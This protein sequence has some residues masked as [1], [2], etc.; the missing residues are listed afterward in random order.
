MNVCRM[1]W[2]NVWRNRRR[3]IVTIAAMTL[4]LWVMV[5]YSGMLVGY[6]RGMER[7]VLDLELGDIQIF[8]SGY[9]EKPSLYTAIVRPEALLLTLDQAGFRSSARL[10]GGGLAAAGDNSAGVSLRGVDIERDAEGSRVGAWVAK[11]SWLDDA[12]RKGVGIGRRLSKTLTVAPGD[13]LVVLSQAADGS[14]ATDLYTVRGVL[15]GISDGGDRS[16]VFMTEETFR[17]LM[18]FP[19]GAHQVI[20][21]KPTTVQIDAAAARVRGLAP[22]L[23]VKSWRELIPVIATML[24]SG[25]QM[26]YIVFFIMYLAVGILILNAMLMAVFER[27]REFGVLKALGV[28]PLRVFGLILIESAVQTGIAMVIGLTLSLPCMWY[29]STRGIDTGEMGGMSIMG[30][31]MD[32][33]WYGVYTPESVVGPVFML[34]LIVMLA[35]LYPALK[36]AWIRPVRAM[37]HL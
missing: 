1:G 4:A 6:F 9:L 27:I 10:L 25:Q 33:I 8:A 14:L 2:R 12:D 31:A 35:I 36:A 30:V 23:D 22:D 32:P 5:L 34:V 26:M 18:V 11:G 15:K 7:N 16:T 19:A 24:D 3:S 20:V 37:H 21:R 28:G 29:L 17:E 13:E